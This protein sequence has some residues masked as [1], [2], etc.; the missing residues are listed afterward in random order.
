MKEHLQRLRL[1]REF[2]FVDFNIMV[3]E[4]E[5]REITESLGKSRSIIASL[6]RILFNERGQ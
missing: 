1:R 6:D 5:E 4:E 2:E 3:F